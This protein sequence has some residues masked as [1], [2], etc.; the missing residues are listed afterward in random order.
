MTPRAQS[1]RFRKP[2]IQEKVSAHARMV[3][4]IAEESGATNVIGWEA[5]DRPAIAGDADIERIARFLAEH[6]IDFGDGFISPRHLAEALVRH[7]ADP[8][9]GFVEGD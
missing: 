8:H 6:Q 1:D 2:T 7:L 3:N 4:K 9:K 5:F